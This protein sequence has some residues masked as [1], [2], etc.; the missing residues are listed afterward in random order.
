MFNEVRGYS[1]EKEL[2]LGEFFTIL[3]RYAHHTGW[4]DPSS[5]FSF[6]GSSFVKLLGA[7]VFG[8]QVCN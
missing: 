7:L 1:Q 8:Q 2:S 5:S 3:R 6:G 4:W